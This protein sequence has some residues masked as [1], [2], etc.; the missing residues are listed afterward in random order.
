[1]LL[2]DAMTMHLEELDSRPTYILQH[3]FID[4][5]SPVRSARLKKVMAFFM[6]TMYHSNWPARFTTLAMGQ[7]LDS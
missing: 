6:E 5:P 1:M 2:L 7:R 3:L 4:H